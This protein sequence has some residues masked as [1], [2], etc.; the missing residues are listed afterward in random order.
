MSDYWYNKQFDTKFWKKNLSWSNQF[1]SNNINSIEQNYEKYP[2]RNRWNCNCHVIHDDDFDEN[3][4]PINYGFLR[5]E[6]TKVCGVFL[7]EKNIDFDFHLGDIW[8]NYY[9]FGQFQE[10][11]VHG[12]TFTVV[13]Y[14][15]YDK[16]KHSKTIFT[17]N[18]IKL[19]D[20]SQG[21]I[22]IFPGFYEHFV[23][24]NT[25]NTPRLTVAFGLSLK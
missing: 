25:S 24:K 18:V 21:D 10:P 12:S 3:I 14:L 7:R 6:Y 22:V 17:D 23:E 8:Y 11:H 13:H 1:V 5:E 2:T 20:I 16:E 4:I 19:P 15:I 9:K